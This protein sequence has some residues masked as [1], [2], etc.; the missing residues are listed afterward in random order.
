M[1]NTEQLT[2]KALADSLRSAMDDAALVAA[3]LTKRGYDVTLDFLTYPRSEYNAL[4]GT[5]FAYKGTEYLPKTK[6][7]KTEEI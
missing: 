5:V 6:I 7:W 3:E 1:V 4:A 2:D